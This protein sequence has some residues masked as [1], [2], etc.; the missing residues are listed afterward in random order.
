MMTNLD[1]RDNGLSTAIQLGIAT[2]SWTD[3]Q[4]KSKSSC[5]VHLP[6]LSEGGRFSGECF[7]TLAEGTVKGTSLGCI[8]ST[9]LL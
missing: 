4:N 5:L 6:W 3:Y 9:L 1:H 8:L 2:S 7:N